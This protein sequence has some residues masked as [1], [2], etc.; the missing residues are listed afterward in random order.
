MYEL[1]RIP[2]VIQVAQTRKAFA[3]LHVTGVNEVRSTSIENHS[4]KKWS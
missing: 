3:A 2:V 1:E 4:V